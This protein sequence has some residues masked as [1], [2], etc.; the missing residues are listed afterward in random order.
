MWL[1]ES[2]VCSHVVGSSQSGAR[3]EDD[4][5]AAAPREKNAR[6]RSRRMLFI[7]LFCLKDD[8]GR[9]DPRYP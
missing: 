7:G 1:P 4:P 2:G 5:Q 9:F 6:V 8:L 3:I